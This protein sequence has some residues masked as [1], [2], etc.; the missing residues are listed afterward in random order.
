MEQLIR[1]RRRLQQV[2]VD[3]AMRYRVENRLARTPITQGTP[4]DQ[5]RALGMG[6]KVVCLVQQ[7]ASGHLRER[8]PGEDQGDLVTGGG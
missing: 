6:M 4:L 3:P 2:V 7:V 1:G 5:Q 8:F